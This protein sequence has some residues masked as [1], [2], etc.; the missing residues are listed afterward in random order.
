MRPPLP[1][2]LLSETAQENNTLNISPKPTHINHL[3]VLISCATHRCARLTAASMELN[4]ILT[5]SFFFF[6]LW[7][8][9]SFLA[10]IAR[11]K[12]GTSSQPPLKT[13]QTATGGGV[14]TQHF[15]PERNRPGVCHKTMSREV[16]REHGRA[17][18]AL[19]AVRWQI[20]AYAPRLSGGKKGGMRAEHGNSSRACRMQ[21]ESGRWPT[22]TL[23]RLTLLMRCI[24]AFLSR[25]PTEL[26]EMSQCIF[27]MS[28]RSL[29]GASARN[30]PGERRRMLTWAT[31]RNFC[32]A[33]CAS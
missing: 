9:K 22:R 7:N 24:T 27:D 23:V 29:T 25:E 1:P 20:A 30:A 33:R 17:L 26:R 4:H 16:L 14:K 12:A 3:S 11:S 10:F 13:V 5:F 28:R 21:G 15:P 2:A 31:T 32:A 19:L 8:N 18:A 6:F